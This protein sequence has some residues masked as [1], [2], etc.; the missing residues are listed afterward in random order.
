[1][2]AHAFSE[3]FLHANWHTDN[4]APILISEVELF[5]YNYI[6][7]RCKAT[8]GVFFEEVG[9][10]ETHVHVVVRIEPQVDISEFFGE[11]KGAFSFEANKHFKRKFLYWQRGFGVVSFSKKDLP[12]VIEY[13]RRQKEHHAPGGTLNAK[14]ERTDPDAENG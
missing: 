3:I 1:M 10:I 2:S 14:L 5:V 4:D 13:V 7:N 9:G 6:R 8:N 12:W 11:L